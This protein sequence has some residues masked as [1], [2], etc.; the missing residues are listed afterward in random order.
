MLYQ[1]SLADDPT[2]LR[3]IVWTMK[4]GTAYDVKKILAS[5]KGQVGFH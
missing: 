2:A 5:L 3:R 4:A 1:G